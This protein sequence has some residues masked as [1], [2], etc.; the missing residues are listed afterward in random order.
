MLLTVS[1]TNLPRSG[2]ALFTRSDG[3][4]VGNRQQSEILVE[5]GDF[6][7]PNLQSTPCYK[8]VPVEILS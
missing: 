5:N 1:V 2:A 6:Y 3:R 8:E 4:T 7:I